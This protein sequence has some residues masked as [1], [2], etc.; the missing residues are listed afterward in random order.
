[1]ARSR[2]LRRLRRRPSGERQV[3]S[4]A[5][6]LRPSA[7]RSLWLQRAG[8]SRHARHIVTFYPA[9]STYTSRP[10]AA[11]AGFV[12][13]RRAV[14][15]SWR[16]PPGAAGMRPR[17]PCRSAPGRGPAWLRRLT[18]GQESRSSNLLVPT[19]FRPATESELRRT[20]LLR[21]LASPGPRVTVT[22]A[23]RSGGCCNLM[24][25]PSRLQQP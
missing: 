9:P 3:P 23:D 16:S 1:L 25:L 18:G 17:T 11:G 2:R 4:T 13:G 7:R 6:S 12:S 20:G 21:T 14:A 24:A 22:R 10:G 5:Q 8:R 19:T 15:L